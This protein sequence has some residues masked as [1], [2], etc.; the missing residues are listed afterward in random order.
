MGQNK[1]ASLI[2]TR[3]GYASLGIYIIHPIIINAL[4]DGMLGQDFTTVIQRSALTIPLVATITFILS[5]IAVELIMVI[6]VIRRI[7]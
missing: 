7:V 3:L 5:Y 6:P 1:K 2:F 4:N